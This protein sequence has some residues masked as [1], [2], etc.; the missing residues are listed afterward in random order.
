VWS[1]A[2]K[3]LGKFDE[4]VLTVLDGD[5]YP[6]SVRVNPL[7]YDAATGQLPAT[8]LETLGAVEGPANLLC[9]YHD[10][11]MWNIKAIQ[12]K[13]RLEKRDSGWVFVSTSFNPPSKLAMLSALKNAGT[14]AQK[15]LDKRGLKRPDV[16][17]VA[18]KEIQRRVSEQRP[19]R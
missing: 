1:E 8:L 2:A 9:H 6:V 14:S 15:Y 13:G 17:W 11:K 4:A 3:W 7:T 19:K 12:I 5:G 10:E 16:D 18:V